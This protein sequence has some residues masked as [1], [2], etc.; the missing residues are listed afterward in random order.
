LPLLVLARLIGLLP[1]NDQPSLQ[2]IV[3]VV[4]AVDI[5]LL[6]ALQSVQASMLADL[7]EQSEVRTGRRSEGIF[8]AAVTFTRKSTGGFGALIAGLILSI[9]GFPNGADPASVDSE[10]LQNLGTWY[11]PTLLVLY[12]FILIAVSF[13]RIDRHTHQNN[14][15]LLAKQKAEAS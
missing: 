8:Y 9:V 12:S 11:A 3:L 4:Y 10:T 5:M 13:Y 15:D 2:I 6:I 7:V 1:E 14:L